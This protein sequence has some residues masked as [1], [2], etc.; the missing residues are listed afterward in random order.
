MP[1][2]GTDVAG[3]VALGGGLAT[4]G[5]LLLVVRRHRIRRATFEPAPVKDASRAIVITW[6]D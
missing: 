4:A 1:S 2:T 6:H 3:M 5:V